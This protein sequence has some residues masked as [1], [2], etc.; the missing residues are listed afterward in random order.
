MISLF[1]ADQIDAV[2]IRFISTWV[3]WAYGN[4]VQFH[5]PYKTMTPLKDL[6]KLQFSL[7]LLTDGFLSCGEGLQ[8]K[9][10][11][12]PQ[13]LSTVMYPSHMISDPLG[14]DHMCGHT[15]IWI[16]IC[17]LQI[18]HVFEYCVIHGFHLIS[19]LP[20]YEILIK[21]LD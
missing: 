2:L 4:F 17:N 14:G 6:I 13:I 9:I 15:G 21:L 8:F 19:W 16:S 18:L 1:F 7:V 3:L 5:L 20:S 11:H 12:Y 10:C